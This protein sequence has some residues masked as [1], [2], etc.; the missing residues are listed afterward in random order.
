MFYG[1]LIALAV[2]L[3]IAFSVP[4]L[5]NKMSPSSEYVYYEVKHVY[6]PISTLYS[7]KVTLR[8]G[9][10]ELVIPF[11]YEDANIIEKGDIITFLYNG[12]DL[13]YL[14][15]VTKEGGA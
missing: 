10:E 13:A 14:V 6:F 3:I 12:D 4:F 8:K 2:M 9:D 15:E 1:S 11:S 7:P 5:Y